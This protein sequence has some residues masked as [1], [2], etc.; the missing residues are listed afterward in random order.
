MSQAAA[1]PRG[2]N[3]QVLLHLIVG[4]ALDERC[5]RNRLV[6]EDFLSERYGHNLGLTVLC[7]PHSLESDTLVFRAAS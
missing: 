6:L 3:L 1:V 2:I 5:Q 4:L 7:V